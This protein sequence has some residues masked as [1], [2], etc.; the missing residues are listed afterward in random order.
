MKNISSHQKKIFRITGT[1]IL[2]LLFIMTFVW[3]IVT[4]KELYRSGEL[5]MNY[6]EEHNPN[7]S[8]RTLSIDLIRPWMTFDYINFIFKLPPEYLKNTLVVTD[9]RYPN[10]RIDRYVKHHN[11]NTSL[12]L[13]NI[14]Q[15]I[16]NY[17][18]S[19]PTQAAR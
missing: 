5:Q 12:F 10:I 18:T 15:A 17:P 9:P 13:Q 3:F 7:Y 1:V 8:N 16:T 4:T 19:L 6:A 2:A 11:L 14:K